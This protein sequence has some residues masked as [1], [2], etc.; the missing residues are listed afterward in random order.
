ML[1]VSRVWVVS[2]VLGFGEFFWDVNG[3]FRK[4]LRIFFNGLER[5]RRA[6]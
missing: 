6:F 3:N 5:L 1:R 4:F 2:G